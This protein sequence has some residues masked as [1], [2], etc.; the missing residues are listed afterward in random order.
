MKKARGYLEKARCELT[1]LSN[2]PRPQDLKAKSSWTSLPGFAKP[3]LGLDPYEDIIDAIDRFLKRS[4]GV[5]DQGDRRKSL[6]HLAV[7]KLVELLEP[8]GGKRTITELE[9]LCQDLFDR[10]RKQHEGGEGP[11][12]YDDMLGRIVGNKQQRSDREKRKP[13]KEKSKS[14]RRMSTRLLVRR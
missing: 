1:T 12:S 3:E 9:V 2:E 11:F 5:G 7:S 8:E 13:K 10:V 4:A 14:A 6:L